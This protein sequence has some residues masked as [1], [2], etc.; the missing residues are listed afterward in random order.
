MYVCSDLAGEHSAFHEHEA[1]TA[2][3]RH[4]TPARTH[5]DEAGGCHSSMARKC[6]LGRQR[7]NLRRSDAARCQ[8]ESQG[9]SQAVARCS[10]SLIRIISRNWIAVPSSPHVSTRAAAPPGSK[11]SHPSSPFREIARGWL[12]LLNR[13]AKRAEEVRPTRDFRGA[14]RPCAHGTS[15]PTT[16]RPPPSSTRSGVSAPSTPLRAPV[17]PWHAGSQD[18]RDLPRPRSHLAHA[19]PSRF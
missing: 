15:F 14:S 10:P 1:G 13:P 2:H 4:R 5:R 9:K 11:F 7:P 12:A 16:T 3:R 8:V 18:R 17:A 6:W 19:K